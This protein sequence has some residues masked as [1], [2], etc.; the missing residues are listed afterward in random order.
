MRKLRNKVIGLLICM[1]C[2]AM[3]VGCANKDFTD[4]NKYNTGGVTEK[5]DFDAP[6]TIESDDLVF[7]ETEF[8]RFSDYVYDADRR[9]RFKMTKNENGSYTISE[10]EDAVIECETDEEFASKLQQIIRDFGLIEYNGVNRQTAGLAPEYGPY[11]VDASY[12]SDEKLYFYMNGDPDA[13]W[14]WEV[15]D[16]FANEFGRN[17]ITDLLP[18]KEES[19]ITRFSLYYSNGDT[20]YMFEEIPESVT[21]EEYYESIKAIVDDSNLIYFQNGELIPGNF[22]S[23]NTPD[24]YE[25]Y[26]EY[27]NGNRMSGFSDDPVQCEKFKAI[28]EKFA[29]WYEAH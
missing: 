12:A 19:A 20:T 28:A 8:Y 4:S 9:Y 24:F 2:S 7:F 29:D 3:F 22:N 17:G 25:F 13:R 6:K 21:E 1:G 14:T 16:L 18:H 10:C 23:A 5:T 27:E 11:W 26:I 15:L